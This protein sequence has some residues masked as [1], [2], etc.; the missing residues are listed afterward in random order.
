[1]TQELSARWLGLITS[2]PTKIARALIG[3]LKHDLPADH[4]QLRPLV[5]QQLMTFRE[6]VVAALQAE[7]SQTVTARWSEGHL[8][9]RGFQL[10][11][12]FYAKRASGSAVGTASA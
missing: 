3:G 5:P 2:V 12:A 9:F 7:Q 6:S 8:M 11:N 1:L 4:A 10:D